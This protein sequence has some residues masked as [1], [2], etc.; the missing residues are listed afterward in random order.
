MRHVALHDNLSGRRTKLLH[1]MHCA[2]EAGSDGPASLAVL[3][4]DLNESNDSLFHAPKSH[5][6]SSI[7][8]IRSRSTFAARCL[9]AI[10]DRRPLMFHAHGRQR[11][12]GAKR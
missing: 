5:S 6:K 11:Y 9:H 4:M 1:S 12:G 8:A 7:A 3:F 2:I 10:L